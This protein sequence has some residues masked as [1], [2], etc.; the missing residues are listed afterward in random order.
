[1]F[2]A[3]NVLI[4]CKVHRLF[5]SRF[6]QM[7]SGDETL[8]PIKILVNVWQKKSEFFKR[9]LFFTVHPS[10][11][12]EQPRPNN[13]NF[14]RTKLRPPLNADEGHKSL[15]NRRSPHLSE[16]RWRLEVREPKYLL[17]PLLLFSHETLTV[18]VCY[19]LFL[20]FFSPFSL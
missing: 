7:S 20:H 15:Q 6:P 12:S 19:F 3:P 14:I 8:Q 17:R 10:S 18:S 16:L 9:I 2:F 5:L 4:G 13:S 11:R 1:M